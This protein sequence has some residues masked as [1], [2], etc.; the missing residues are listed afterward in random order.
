MNL[1]WQKTARKEYVY[2]F[3]CDSVIENNNTRLIVADVRTRFEQL[4]RLEKEDY[5]IPDFGAEYNSLFS[6]RSMIYVKRLDM[7]WFMMPTIHD[8]KLYCYDAQ[9]ARYLG[10]MILPFAISPKGIMVA[11]KGYDCDW[12][13]DLHFYKRVGN[14]I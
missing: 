7:C 3:F 10:E 4:D 5:D 1:I 14:Y 8:C 12:P 9:S 13:L 6:N 2:D 11:Q